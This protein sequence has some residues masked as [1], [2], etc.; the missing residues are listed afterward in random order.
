MKTAIRVLT[1]ALLVALALVYILHIRK[2]MSDFGVCYRGG[3]RILKGETLYRPSDGHLQF[4]YAPA[5]ALFFAG[6]AVLPFEAAK[7]VWYALSLVFIFGIARMGLNLLP[8][9][10]LRREWIGA[11]GFLVMAKF[12]AREIELGQVNLL[13][14]FLLAITATALRLDRPIPA[15][16]AAGLSLFLKPYAFV[17]WPYFLLRRKGKALTASI[18]AACAGFLLPMAVYGLSGGLSVHREWLSSLR[19]S[20]QDLLA[21]GDNASLSAFVLKNMAALSG[22]TVAVILAASALVLG[23]I[24]L[25]VMRAGRKVEAT[26]PEGLEI[27]F[28]MVLI[29]MFSPLGWIYNYFYGFWAILFLIAGMMHFPGVVRWL[30][31]INLAV[32]GLTVIEIVGRKAFDFYNGH[33]L[34]AVNFLV[35]LAGLAWLRFRGRV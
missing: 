28:L 11:L 23:L 2:D 15:G 10:S 20:S 31:A 16:I 1:A 3:E 14:L 13:I 4:K 29:P 30:I 18:G 26:P 25:A 19:L 35:V 5:S 7:A 27:A 21:A 22:G 34:A 12:L 17:V 8:P 6:L 24:F 32:I 9:S 33:A